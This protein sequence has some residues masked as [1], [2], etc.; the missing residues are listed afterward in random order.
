MF[1]PSVELDAGVTIGLPGNRRAVM[2]SANA[3]R[4]ASVSTRMSNVDFMHPSSRFRLVQSCSEQAPLVPQL[5]RHHRLLADEFL[6]LARGGWTVAGEVVVGE[7]PD[8][9]DALGERPQRT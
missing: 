9:L 5:L 7:S 1:S 3:V 2:R 8:H 4:E 6:E